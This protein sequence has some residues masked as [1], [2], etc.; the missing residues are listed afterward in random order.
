MGRSSVQ[1]FN[2]HALRDARVRAGLT[3]KAAAD[4]V[5]VS[6]ASYRQWEKVQGHKPSA[7]RLPII[8]EAVGV[9]VDALFATSLTLAD[10]RAQ[11]G[12]TQAGLAELVGVS[13]A[14][15]ATW[16]RGEQRIAPRYHGAVTSV[17]GV[18]PKDMADPETT[19]ELRA[20]I[21]QSNAVNGEHPS[22]TSD[23]GWAV[24]VPAIDLVVGDTLFLE[25]VGLSKSR[26]EVLTVVASTISGR[27]VTVD[28][29]M[30]AE[31]PTWHRLV[32]RAE[33]SVRIRG[34]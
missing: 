26:Y 8:A 2:V 33:T 4:A 23:R 7:P 15:V 30:E 3:Q 34:R 20:R 6:V 27:T 12:L 10:H 22:V 9:A 24:T 19:A 17:L 18:A 28:L 11:A 31:T 5:G 1:G 14:L 16:E 21:E 29:A 13:R 25:S 32:L